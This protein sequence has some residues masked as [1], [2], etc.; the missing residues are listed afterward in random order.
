MPN[1]V[2]LHLLFTLALNFISN[3][4][5]PIQYPC[6]NA[7][8]LADGSVCTY[9]FVTVGI[10]AI[11]WRLRQNNTFVLI[12]DDAVDYPDKKFKYFA[13]NGLRIR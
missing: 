7:P 10:Y 9:Q 2:R 8:K 11:R 5:I 4:V 3:G 13:I 12:D 6:M 1:F